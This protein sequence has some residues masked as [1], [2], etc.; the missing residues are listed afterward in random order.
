MFKVPLSVS[1]PVCDALEALEDDPVDYVDKTLQAAHDKMLTAL[2]ALCFELN[3]MTD[4]SDEG[5]QVLEMS[6]PSTS[7]ERNE[8]NRQACTAR[9]AFLPAYRDV[10]NLLNA[11]GWARRNTGVSSRSEAPS[12]TVELKCAFTMGDDVRKIL[13]LSPDGL[14][15]GDIGGPYFLVVRASNRGAVGI[16]IAEAG[17]QIDCAAKGGML[18]PFEF[19]KFGPGGQVQLPPTLGSHAGFSAFAN[20]KDVGAA[21][22]KLVGSGLTPQRVRPWVLTGAGDKFDGPW[23]PAMDLLPL[24]SVADPTPGPRVIYGPASLFLTD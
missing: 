6:Y 14:P 8:L 11:R 22:M 2:A 19:D 21:L 5:P 12:L 24:I 10:I 17:V 18:A 3:G 20:P 13:P 9:D 1:N 23:T 4:I 7:E 16:E 15:S